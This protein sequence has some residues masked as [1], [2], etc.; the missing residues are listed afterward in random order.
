MCMH[1]TA[2]FVR[3]LE[4]EELLVLCLGQLLPGAVVK[5][6]QVMCSFSH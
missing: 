6:S 2:S 4:L 1:L 5:A 3:E